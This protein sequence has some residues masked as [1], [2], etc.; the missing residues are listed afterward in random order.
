MS[1]ALALGVDSANLV[2][3]PVYSTQWTMYTE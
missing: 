2:F 1:R 3:G